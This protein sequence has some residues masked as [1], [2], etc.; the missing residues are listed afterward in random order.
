MLKIK[1][2]FPTLKKFAENS[3][4][5][6]THVY[7]QGFLILDRSKDN[8]ANIIAEEALEY[9]QRGVVELV[10]KKISDFEYQY[11]A[12]RAAAGKRPFVG[13]YNQDPVE[14]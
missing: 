11:I 4:R 1:N 13:S 7:H 2:K 12:V 8:T 14:A 5:G 6:D 3:Q 9:Y 10:Q